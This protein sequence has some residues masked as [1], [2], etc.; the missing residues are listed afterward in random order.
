MLFLEAGL[1]AVNGR[2]EDKAA[3]MKAL[4][5]INL[6]DT[7]Q[8]PIR[9]DPYGNPIV[10]V[11]IRRVERRDGR[12]MNVVID[13]YKDVSQF[14]K[15]DPAAFLAARCTRATTHRRR[16]SSDG[17]SARPPIDCHGRPGHPQRHRGDAARAF[18]R[19]P[20][21]RRRADRGG[22]RRREPAA[23]APRHRRR[24]ALRAARP[25][26]RP[27]AHGERGGPV[28][29]RGAP[30]QHAR[31][32]R[33]RAVRR[34]DDLRP[35]RRAAQRAAPPQRPRHHR[36]R[37]SLVARRLLHA[38]D[39]ERRGALRRDAGGLAPGRDVLQALLQRLP[40]AA[41]RGAVLA[42]RPV[43]R[44]H[45]LPIA[46]VLRRARRPR[47]GRRALRGHRPDHPHGGAREGGG[48]ARPRGLER[49][50]AQRRRVDAGRLGHRAGAARGRAALHRPP[51]DSRGRRPR[52]RRA[53]PRRGGVVGGD[54][55]PPH[56]YGRHGSRDRL[57]GQGEPAAARGPRPRAALARPPRRRHHLPRLGPRH[58]RPHAGHEGKGRRPAP[59]HLGRA[60]RQPRRPRAL[61]ARAHDVRRERR[62]AV[63]GGP[64][65]RGRREHGPGVRA[66]PAQGRRWRR[67]PTPT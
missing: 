55:A 17:G 35:L 24:R 58:R 32:D 30:R 21:H 23:G 38:R 40:G 14:W 61:P 25:H 13:T 53:G 46:P 8:G 64:G 34:R 3:F 6:P 7:P 48:P 49:R 41:R 60:V 56:A 33:G 10:N 4:R 45:A 47:R 29:P 50:P 12:L 62:P 11:Y 43:R 42:R 65:A 66:L 63:H 39:R 22:G 1:K 44:R 19:R 31:G 54:A 27:R 57:L 36:A 26:R 16:T 67:A 20:G 2:I 5:A 28:D 9:L 15:Y 59:E 37:Q 18:P 52:R 51:L